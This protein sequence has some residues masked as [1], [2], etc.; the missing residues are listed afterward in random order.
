M[1]TPE[2]R[3]TKGYRGTGK[4]LLDVGEIRAV[5]LV[6]LVQILITLDKDARVGRVHLHQI[7]LISVISAHPVLDGI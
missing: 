6:R 3:G 1:F 2:V 5:H 7:L 4:S